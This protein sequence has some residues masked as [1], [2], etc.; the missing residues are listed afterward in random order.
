MSIYNYENENEYDI[1][2]IFEYNKSYLYLKNI[3]FHLFKS[4]SIN[5]KELKE[6]LLNIAY[7]MNGLFAG[8]S[9]LKELPDISKWNLSNVKD[10]SNLFSGCS[11][12]EKLPDISK[13]NTDN[14]KIFLKIVH[15]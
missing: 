13:W 7:N 3:S 8:C 1:Q 15:H 5:K 11:S 4:E 10:I 2:K 14:I 12:L 6:N 9:S